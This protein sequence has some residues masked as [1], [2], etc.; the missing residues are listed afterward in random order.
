MGLKKRDELTTRRSSTSVS[1]YLRHAGPLEST[2]THF[3]ELGPVVDMAK[4]IPYEQLNA[5]Q[6]GT[7]TSC[8]F[9]VHLTLFYPE[10]VR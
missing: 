8:T 9:I 10:C 1:R 5:Q 7:S 2:R 4:E 6:V 3:F